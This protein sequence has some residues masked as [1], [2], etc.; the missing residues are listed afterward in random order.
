MRLSFAGKAQMR[1]YEKK[2]ATVLTA[3]GQTEL[4]RIRAAPFS[5]LCGRNNCGKSYLLKLLVERIGE[6]ASYLGPQRY[7]NFNIL[8][9]YAPQQNRRSERWQQW[10]R[11]W[12]T[13]TQNLDN[14]PINLQQAIAELPNTKRAQLI[15]IMHELLGSDMEILHTIP[16]NDM[17]QKYVAVDGHNLSYTSS[18]Y[19]LVASLVSSL[20]SDEHDAYLIDEPEL[21]VSPETQSAFADFLFNETTRKKYF[22]HIKTLI[23]A[24]HSTV[25]LDRRS[26][27]NNHFVEKQ[28]DAIDIERASRVS[29]VNRI[30][31]FLLGNRLES[32]YM[33]SAIVVVEGKTDHAYIEKALLSRY[34]GVQFSVIS[35]NTDNRIREIFY[36]TKTLFG[37]LQKSP[38]YN[39]VFAVIDAVHGSGLRQQLVQMGM[40]ND[41]IVV[42]NKNG[43]EYYY[44]PNLLREIF[45]TDA[46]IHIRE[47]VV[48]AGGLKYTKSELSDLVVARVSAHSDFPQEFRDEFLSK[49]ERAVGVSA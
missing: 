6:S 13:A 26:I 48:E 46:E 3:R 41:N 39:R 23:L 21:G 8:T 1:D 45:S 5:V 18:G 36:L 25:F 49:I 22:G 17:S 29:D 7:Q 35:A 33:P 43:I 9:P 32:L 40:P 30:H 44:P 20:L 10:L 28:G 2:P 24:T 38:Y 19:R 42:W 12:K 34:D 14:S 15:E 27:E 37:D 31:F 4:D 11:Q 47:D 16:E